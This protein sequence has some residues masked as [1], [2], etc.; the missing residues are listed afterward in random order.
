MSRFRVGAAVLDGFFDDLATEVLLLVFDVTFTA[1]LVCLDDFETEVDR[2]SL[3]AVTVRL[4]RIRDFPGDL[5]PGLALGF[6]L[7]L[8]TEELRSDRY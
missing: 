5:L 8:A 2:L 1:D 7:L 6:W 3:V 4:P